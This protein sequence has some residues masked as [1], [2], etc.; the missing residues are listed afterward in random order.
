MTSNECNTNFLWNITLQVGIAARANK[1]CLICCLLEGIGETC[2][3]LRF[4]EYQ[5][6]VVFTVRRFLT[7]SMVRKSY[8]G[9]ILLSWAI[10][11]IR[12]QVAFVSRFFIDVVL[13]YFVIL[14]LLDLSPLT[15]DVFFKC[16]ALHSGG[17]RFSL[18]RG[19]FLSGSRHVIIMWTSVSF[20]KL[21]R[22]LIA[23]R[24]LG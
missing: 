17:F 4:E 8:K 14:Q 15:F 19:F 12:C 24:M 7:V 20:N 2:Y 5:Q 23:R 9:G 6:I 18:E 21:K 1:L 3:L 22:G 11:C 10:P 16:L 13:I